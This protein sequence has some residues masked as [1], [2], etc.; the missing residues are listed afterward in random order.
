VIVVHFLVPRRDR[1]G[2]PY[3]CSVQQQVRR[4]L[5]RLFHGWSSL[6]AGALPGA[7]RNPESGEV[8]YDES[9]RY[10]IGIDPDRLS[11]LDSYLSHLA[12]RLGQN[13]LW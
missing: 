13:A 9:W 7:W 11:D 3:P 5:E 12:H 4:D 10:E 8:E 6:G 2:K 1:S